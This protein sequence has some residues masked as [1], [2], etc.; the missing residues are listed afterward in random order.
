VIGFYQVSRLYDY[1]VVSTGAAAA[2]ELKGIPRLKGIPF[3]RK[4]S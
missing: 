1:N 3:G 2:A 4:W